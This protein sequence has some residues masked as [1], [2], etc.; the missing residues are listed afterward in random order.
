MLDIY[1]IYIKNNYYLL[2][3]CF[4][5]NIK[6][7]KTYFLSKYSLKTRKRLFLKLKYSLDEVKKIL[8][9]QKR[10]IEIQKKRLI[11]NKSKNI[12]NLKKN[13]QKKNLQNK[14]ISLNK[15]FIKRSSECFINTFL[16]N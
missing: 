16:V 10:S 8:K 3:T 4:P 2:I 13:S 1:L 11:K 14:A 7:K 5:F 12:F 6:K 9:T 15:P